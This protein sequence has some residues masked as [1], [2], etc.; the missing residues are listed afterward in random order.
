MDDLIAW[1]TTQHNGLRTY[2]AF[3]QR[4]LR[5][6]AENPRHSALFSLLASL[7]GRFMETY[8]EQPLPSDVADDAFKRLIALVR[9]A[10]ETMR[11]SETDQLRFLNKLAVAELG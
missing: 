3:Q 7:V 11:L 10:A 6:A 5:L 2:A 1:L 8:D 4:I 9:Q